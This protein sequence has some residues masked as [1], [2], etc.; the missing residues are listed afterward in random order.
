M[1]MKS[2][3]EA[4]DYGEGYSRSTDHFCHEPGQGL[5]AKAKA[6]AADGTGHLYRPEATFTLKD[7][8]W[9]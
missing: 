2:R 3:R 1:S 4:I 6:E 8:T 9:G 7:M 5:L